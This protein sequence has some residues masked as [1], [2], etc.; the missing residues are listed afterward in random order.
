MA[1]AHGLSK[2]CRRQGDHRKEAPKRK[3]VLRIVCVS[4]TCILGDN[5]REIVSVLIYITV[6]SIK[7]VCTMF[8]IVKWKLNS[9][10]YFLYEFIFTYM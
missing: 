6:F 10:N 8:L 1:G 4:S 7:T 3:E 9:R 2:G 5:G